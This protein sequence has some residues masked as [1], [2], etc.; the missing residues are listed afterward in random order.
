VVSA[1]VGD[2]H[3]YMTSLSG[4]P[5]ETAS[6]MVTIDNPNGVANDALQVEIAYDP[7]MLTPLSVE[8]TGLTQSFLLESNA[9]S[10]VLSV[11]GLG[12]GLVIQGEGTFCK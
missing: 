11:A 8:P 12:S 2:T 3:I 10:G 7:A 9:T 5:G 1:K 6:Q 4:L